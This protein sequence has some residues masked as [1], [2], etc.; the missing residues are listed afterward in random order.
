MHNG[1]VHEYRCSG[2][3]ALILINIFGK[4]WGR[5]QG[6]GRREQR[7]IGTFCGVAVRDF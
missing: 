3:A 6:I 2:G 4:G 5:S 7:P 1:M